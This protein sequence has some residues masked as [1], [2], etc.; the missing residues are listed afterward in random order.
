[1]THLDRK[2]MNK[3]S[4]LLLSTLFIV[5]GCA[6]SQKRAKLMAIQ[7]R[8]IAKLE[9]QLSVKQ[10]T[11]E[12][13]KVQRWV[14]QP[15]QTPE[16]VAFA[17]L[18]KLIKNKQWVLALKESSRLK[19]THPRSVSLMEY[20]YKVFKK[21]GLTKQ[22]IREYKKMQSLRARVSKTRSRKL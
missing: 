6:N 14:G 18:R 4:C 21:M 16:K 11:I 17:K 20:R 5:S 10:K 9:K 8:R 15:V 7:K 22:A 1:M 19:N 12:K 13:M 2:K 3:Y